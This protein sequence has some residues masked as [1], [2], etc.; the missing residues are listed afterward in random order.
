[1]ASL[2]QA[3]LTCIV[4]ELARLSRCFEQLFRAMNLPEGCADLASLLIFR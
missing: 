2:R 1:M 4:V 3:L